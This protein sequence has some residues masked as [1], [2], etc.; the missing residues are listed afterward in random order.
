MTLFV[1]IMFKLSRQTKDCNRSGWLRK[2]MESYNCSNTSLSC[3]VIHPHSYY[4]LRMRNRL[5]APGVGSKIEHVANSFL[6]SIFVEESWFHRQHV[7][8]FRMIHVETNYDTLLDGTINKSCFPNGKRFIKW[9]NKTL[10]VS[11]DTGSLNEFIYS[12]KFGSDVI[13]LALSAIM[14]SSFRRMVNIVFIYAVKRN[15]ASLDT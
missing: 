8:I 15:M 11:R 3:P 14:T 10:A 12:K 13:K 2:M 7:H 6:I 4:H 1:V 5:T 9:P